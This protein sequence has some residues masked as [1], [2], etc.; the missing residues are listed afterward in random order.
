V[1]LNRALHASNLGDIHA[2]PDNHLRLQ[3][4]GAGELRLY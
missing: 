2:Q 1:T 4:R 3:P